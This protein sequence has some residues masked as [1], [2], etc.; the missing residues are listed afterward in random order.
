MENRQEKIQLLETHRQKT[1]AGPKAH[2][3]KVLFALQMK[4][5]AH[6]HHTIILP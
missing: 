3:C 6:V 5:A 4:C 2:A 1:F